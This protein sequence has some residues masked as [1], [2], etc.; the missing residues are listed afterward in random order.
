MKKIRSFCSALALFLI[1]ATDSARANDEAMKILS[2]VGSLFS[3]GYAGVNRNNFSD[4]HTRFRFFYESGKDSELTSHSL[5]A[6]F[7][8]CN[9]S[10]KDAGNRFGFRISPVVMVS[11]WS[12]NSASR[13]R[14]AF[15]LTITPQARFIWMV[16]SVNLDLTFGIGGSFLSQ[17]EIGNRIKSTNFQFSDHFGVGISDLSDRI[18][19]GYS[20][21]HISNAGIGTPNQ[22]VD[23]HGFSISYRFE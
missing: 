18:R 7:A 13:E 14:S 21:R 9:L 17:S 1:S 23:F 16:A 6:S 5:G 20:Y 22:S 2:V 10:Q 8:D 19:L 4:C 11:N 12:A 15:E 3:Y